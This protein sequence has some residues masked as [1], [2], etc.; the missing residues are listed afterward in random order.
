MERTIPVRELNQHTSA[1]L[2]EVERGVPMTVTRAGKPVARLVPVDDGS[3]QR[4]KRSPYL[5][6]LI[7][8]GRATAATETGPIPMPTPIPGSDP[9]VNVAALLE[10][11]REQE[12]W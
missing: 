10:N 6:H 2:A 3:P 4:R 1:V 8:T 9:S 7:A 5:E 12:R 11:D